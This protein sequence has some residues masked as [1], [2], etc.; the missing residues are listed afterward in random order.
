MSSTIVPVFHCSGISTFFGLFELVCPKMSSTSLFLR[1]RNGTKSKIVFY[2]VF[3]TSFPPKSHGWI[4][5][6]WLSFLSPPGR[7]FGTLCW[8]RFFILNFRAL[9]MRMGSKFG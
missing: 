6:D 5:Q 1:S 9:E 3:W 8:D 7:Y 4:S 2:I